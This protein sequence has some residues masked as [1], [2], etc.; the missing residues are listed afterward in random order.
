MSCLTV[1]L[2]ISLHFI[3]SFSHEDYGRAT[4][5]SNIATQI[6]GYTGRPPYKDGVPSE[7]Y[8]A[9]PGDGDTNGVERRKANAAFVILARNGDLR[10][11][12]SSIKQ[13][14]ECQSLR[15]WVRSASHVTE[16]YPYDP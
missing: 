14:G 2:Q 16:T 10:G 8:Q 3:L 11:I 7:Y 1:G 5:L 4:S 12:A 9:G 13:M 6:K 15:P